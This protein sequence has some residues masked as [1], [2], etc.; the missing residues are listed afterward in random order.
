MSLDLF[1]RETEERL[2]RMTP[3]DR[4]EASAWDGFARGSAMHA[5]QGFAKVARAADLA[6]SVGPILYDKM[7][8][9]TEAQDRYFREHE[10]IFQSAVDFWT[11]RPGEVGWAG[12]VAGSLMSL[13]PLVI[14]SPAGAVATTQLSVAQDLIQKGVDPIKAQQVGAAYGAGIGLGIWVPILG[15]TLTQRML[16][17]GAGFN[18]VQGV[19]MRGVAGEILEGTPAA[20]EFQAFGPADL[21]LDVLLGL[22]FG[23]MAHLSPGMRAQGEEFWQRIETWRRNLTPEQVAALSTLRAAQHASADSLPG[24]PATADAVDAHVARVRAAVEQLA[25]NEPVNVTDLPEARIT[26]DL[27]RMEEAAKNA[28]QLRMDAERTRIEEG[29]PH[30]PDIEAEYGNAPRE[31]LLT[32]RGPERPADAA[33][34]PEVPRTVYEGV[35]EGAPGAGV[36]AVPGAPRRTFDLTT[37]PPE[38]QPR[39][40]ARAVEDALTAIRVDPEEARAGATLWES[41]FRTAADRYA[42]PAARIL[43]QYGVNI[44]RLGE[45]EDLPG[46]LKQAPQEALPEG[47]TVDRRMDLAKRL[48]EARAR[49][50]AAKTE[51]KQ[52]AADLAALKAEEAPQEAI[53]TAT[54]KWKSARE[55][56]GRQEL[57]IKQLRERLER[58]RV[59]AAEMKAKPLFQQGRGQI[60]FG[61]RQTV[62]G[63]FENA[64]RSTFLHETGHFFLQVTRDLA[65]RVNAP[66][67]ALA[68]WG[69]LA[70]WL[71]IEG[72]PIEVE[73]HE[74]FARGFEQYIAEGKAPSEG[75]KAVFEQFKQ[76]LMQIYHSL[77]DFDVNLSDDVRAVMDRM[78]APGK[79]EGPAGQTRPAV[80]PPPRRARE[81]PAGPAGQSQL[82]RDI[83]ALGGIDQAYF[84]DITGEKRFGKTKGLP[85]GVFRPGGKG[86]DDMASQLQARGWPIAEDAV[87][88]GVQALKDM[89]ANEL[90]GKKTVR[91]GEEAEIMSSAATLREMDELAAQFHQAEADAAEQFGFRQNDTGYQAE[92]ARIR[93]QR[94]AQMAELMAAVDDPLKAEAARVAHEKPNLKIRIGE[95]RE[96]KPVTTSLRQYLEDAGRAAEKAAEDAK[97]FDIAAACLEGGA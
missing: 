53:R 6:G 17:G 83:R 55:M 7:T 97:L 13:L 82:M 62:I 10:E 50:E 86:I 70:K 14:T 67:Q 38:Q 2:D 77:T 63:L 72:G 34:L 22:A 84:E 15:R 85:W 56:A 61:D 88:G 33:L 68:D 30:P 20:G 90:V 11:P 75:L 41:F 24:Q 60:Q 19:T 40:I 65:S 29:L 92:I 64:D 31:T 4:P 49:A 36:R 44:R 80:S 78:L 71:K 87:D 73:A 25:R 43:E 89:I 9:G 91:L 23:G 57:D 79:P 12:Q 54:E 16:L 5:M 42:V 3:V 69:T 95:D 48:D 96:G 18:V 74:K 28:Q 81:Q 21:T 58:E 66:P 39:A 51:A 27:P 32:L 59:A 76:W 47:V 94:D 26:P 35:A 52:V 93:E 37:T 1:E 8:D 46:A 45:L